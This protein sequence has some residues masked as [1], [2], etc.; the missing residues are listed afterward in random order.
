M[1]KH[2]K[3]SLGGKVKTSSGGSQSVLRREHLVK[4]LVVDTEFLL[5]ALESWMKCGFA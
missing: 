3:A 5:R 2:S 4:L 1:T